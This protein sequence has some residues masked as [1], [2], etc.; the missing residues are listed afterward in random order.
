MSCLHASLRILAVQAYT[1]SIL[2]KPALSRGVT[3]S[4]VET[5]LRIVSLKHVAATILRYTYSYL[6]SAAGPEKSHGCTQI[7]LRADVAISRT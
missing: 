2:N 1:C 5:G 6:H 4:Q 7:S 3:S